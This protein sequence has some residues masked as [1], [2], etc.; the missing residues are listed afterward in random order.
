MKVALKRNMILDGQ[1]YRADPDGVEV[2]DYINGKPVVLRKDWNPGDE[3]IPLPSDAE[4]W[5]EPV[6]NIEGLLTKG[7]GNSPRA[8]KD[9]HKATD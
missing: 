2:P 8:L 1:R 3:A 5:V 9:L 7:K 6:K 4:L